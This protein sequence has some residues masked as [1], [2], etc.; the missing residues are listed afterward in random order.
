MTKLASSAEVRGITSAKRYGLIAIAG[1]CAVCLLLPPD[2]FL[3]VG[4]G[5]AGVALLC[6]LL[7][8][9]LEGR[10]D[11]L[12]LAWVLLFPLGSY[13]LSFPRSKPLITLDRAIVG[14][15]LA[16][17]LF[18]RRDSWTP[19]G[20]ALRR[21]AWMWALFLTAACLSLLKTGLRPDSL[22]MCSDAFILPALFAWCVIAQFPVR[23]HLRT[24]HVLTCI[25]A[26]YL[27][28]LGVVGLSR[29]EDLVA[30]PGAGTYRA[31][32]GLEKI[33]RVNGPFQTNH[34]FG[35]VG[36]I[37]LFFLL[38]LRKAIQTMPGW[39]R[40]LHWLG[41][42]AA[43]T[44]A[45]LPMFR[46]IALTL[47]LALFINS[48]S[49]GKR[50]AKIWALALAVSAFTILNA[51]LPDIYQERV[52]STENVNARF[53]QMLQNADLFLQNPVLGVGIGNFGNAVPNVTRYSSLNPSGIDPL[54]APHSNWMAILTET[55]LVGLVSYVAAQIMLVAA[56]W[57]M[58][59]GSAGKLVWKYSLFV[60]L[61]YGVSGMTLTSGHYGDLNIWF[62]FTVAALYKYRLERQPVLP[63]EP[64]A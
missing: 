26:I 62:M 14:I 63:A 53:A 46:S 23:R 30:L 60:F 21:G 45:L 37:A 2:W 3:Y 19:L 59:S 55:G 39:Q 7:H 49:G 32:V 18:A 36:L 64:I 43:L 38:F 6:Y 48:W 9:L 56:F 13:F 16:A 44:V 24:L 15:S 33:V 31:G 42:P 25:L 57:K 40:S 51:T 50:T 35:L 52:S 54:N 29:G 10:V 47:L 17:M 27:A 22:R 11:R 41:A 34:S 4:G 8:A 28:V 5:V 61:A 12:I 58:H 1:L 20:R